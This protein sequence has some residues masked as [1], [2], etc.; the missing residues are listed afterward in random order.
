MISERV[1]PHRYGEVLEVVEELAEGFELVE[2]DAALVA[3]AVQQPVEVHVI[4]VRVQLDE[5]LKILDI[6]QKQQLTDCGAQNDLNTLLPLARIEH[7]NEKP[8]DALKNRRWLSIVLRHSR[9]GSCST[10][11]SRKSCGVMYSWPPYSTD[12]NLMKRRSRDGNGQDECVNT[13]LLMPLSLLRVLPSALLKS[14][15]LCGSQSTGSASGKRP[16]WHGS[17]NAGSISTVYG[18]A[19]TMCEEPASPPVSGGV[20]QSLFQLTE[21]FLCTRAPRTEPLNTPLSAA[22]HTNQSEERHWPAP[23]PLNMRRVYANTSNLILHLRQKATPLLS[24]ARSYKL[25]PRPNYESSHKDIRERCRPSRKAQP[26]DSFTVTHVR[27][28]RKILTDAENPKSY[29]TA[30]LIFKKHE[31]EAE[32]I[33]LPKLVRNTSKDQEGKPIKW[34]K[35]K[36]LRFEKVLLSSAIRRPLYAQFDLFQEKRRFRDLGRG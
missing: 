34:L 21:E 15:F 14:G 11:D 35:I 19:K 29:I 32:K 31:K 13:T 5:V 4:F 12:A 22:P 1:H 33:G 26:F 30:N 28:K 25:T 20:D 2:G 7:I 24:A 17:E 6:Q 36:C 23:A 27:N 18:D 3:H 9:L 8:C 10:T 16:L